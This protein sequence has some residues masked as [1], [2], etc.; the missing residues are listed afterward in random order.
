MKAWN[1]EGELSHGGFVP[2][3]RKSRLI[4]LDPCEPCGL[5]WATVLTTRTH[6]HAPAWLLPFQAEIY[7][8]RN[9]LFHW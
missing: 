1:D 5:F 8:P 2:P 6:G 7:A 9:P 3:S 4:E